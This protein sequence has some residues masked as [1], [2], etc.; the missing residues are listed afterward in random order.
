MKTKLTP[1]DRILVEMLE[2]SGLFREQK[3][4]WGPVKYLLG[5]KPVA[6]G[7]VAKLAMGGL[8]TPAKRVVIGDPLIPYQLTPKGEQRAKRLARGEAA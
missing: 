7:T 5:D 2:G 6:E 4:A 8:V 3:Y 1:G